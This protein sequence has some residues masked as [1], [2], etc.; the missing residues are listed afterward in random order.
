MNWRNFFTLSII[1]R[2]SLKLQQVH[3]E[4]PSCVTYLIYSDIRSRDGYPIDSGIRSC[5]R[6]PDY[7]GGQQKPDLTRII[8]NVA[9]GEKCDYPVNLR[10]CM[11]IPLWWTYQRLHGYQCE[12]GNYERVPIIVYEDE[13]NKWISSIIKILLN[14]RTLTRNYLLDF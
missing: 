13:W 4:C 3:I 14:K 6:I 8:I 10:R 12:N 7:F 9:M 1:L 2:I 11:H 5:G